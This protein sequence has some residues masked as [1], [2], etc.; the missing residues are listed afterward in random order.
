MTSSGSTSKRVPRPSHR[1]HAPY[2]ELNEKL[3]GAS[4]SKLRPQCEHA[5]CS[6]N[7]RTSRSSSVCFASVP[8]RLACP[9]G[10]VVAADD[11]DLG[12]TLGEPQRGLE[13][14]GEPAL[15]AGPAHQPVDDHLDRVVL[16]PRQPLL[17]CG[18]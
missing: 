18:R 15:D 9:F 5:R 11:L 14:V 4:S 3:R 13:R 6:E 17:T 16:V 2:G 8:G 10:V 7:V 12:H 1:S